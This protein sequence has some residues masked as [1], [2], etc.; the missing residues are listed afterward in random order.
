MEIIGVITVLLSLIV[1]G[2]GL[3][4]QVKK[5]K[6]RKSVEGLS[7]FYFFI[8]AISYSFWVLY[9]IMLKDWVLIIPMTIGALMSLVVV[10]QFFLYKK[11]ETNKF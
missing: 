9:G 6:E 7:F 10:F 2:L 11:V 1:T 4:A 8:L 3:S 5:N